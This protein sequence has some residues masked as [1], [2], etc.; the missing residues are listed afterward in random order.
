MTTT[1]CDQPEAAGIVGRCLQHDDPDDLTDVTVQR[2]VVGN[3]MT[4]DL[5]LKL[6]ESIRASLAYLDNLGGPLPDHEAVGT[7][8]HH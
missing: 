5:G 7:G 3:G 1:P 4:P 8:F 2:I 6:L